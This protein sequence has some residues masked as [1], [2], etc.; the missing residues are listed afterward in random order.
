MFAL[1]F[2]LI[3]NVWRFHHR[4]FGLLA[5]IEPGV[6]VINLAMLGAVALLPDPTNALGNSPTVSAAVIQF[7]LAFILLTVP[8]LCLL[9]RAQATDAW[10]H[11]AQPE[12]FAW[13]VR[14]W[15]PSIAILILVLLVALFSPVLALAI[16][17]SSG[18]L[19]GVTMALLAPRS[20]AEWGFDQGRATSSAP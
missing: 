3:A 2:L 20:Y 19:A 16:L 4:L 5:F 15:I 13:I 14:S 6:I 12:T 17:T 1:G 10:L 18:L 7:A 8:Y 11:Q 9:L